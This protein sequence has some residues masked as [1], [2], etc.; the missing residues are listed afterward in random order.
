MILTYKFRVKDKNH[1]V[2]LREQHWKSNLVWNFCVEYQHTCINFWPSHF[3]LVNATKEIGKEFG[4]HSDTR[5]MLCKQFVQSRNQFKKCPK[6]RSMKK[7]LG[8]IPYI[9]RAVQLKDDSLTFQKRKYR[10]WKHREFNE[11]FKTGAFVQDAMGH[12]FVT[13][14]TE[15]DNSVQAPIVSVGIDLGLKD[16]ATLSDGTKIEAKK[17]YRDME[18]KLTTAQ[19]AKNKKRVK[20]IHAKIKNRRHHQLHVESARITKKYRNIIVGDVSSSALAKTNMAKSVMDAGWC[21]F[22]EMLRYKARRHQGFFT[23][24]NE[25]YSTQTCSNCGCLPDSRPK[26]IA[27]L[28]I[29]TWECS[30]CG[31]KHDRDHNAALNILSFGLERQPLVEEISAL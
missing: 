8:W 28:G 1:L 3:D 31:T 12:W 27:G 26:G 15:V 2:A 13:F 4:V 16:L 7:S 10:F 23:V 5:N 18:D 11:K 29:R 21:S 20:A 24:V 9:R 22:K 6:F 14:V 30:D 25:N 17:F 19:R